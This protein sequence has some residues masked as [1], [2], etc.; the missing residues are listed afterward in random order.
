MNELTQANAAGAFKLTENSEEIRTMSDI[1]K[2]R[3]TTFAIE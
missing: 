1:L 3:V 2:A